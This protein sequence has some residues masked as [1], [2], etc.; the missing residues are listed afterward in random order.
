MIRSFPNEAEFEKL[1]KDTIHGGW[2]GELIN[3]RKDGSEFP[4][5]LSTSPIRDEKGDLIAL[6]GVAADITERKKEH[7][8]LI[9]AKEK[10]EESDRLKSAF[11]ANMSHEI[12][13][14]L[15]AIIGF[16]SLMIDEASDPETISKSRIILTSGM[17]LLGLVEDIL[18][19]SMIETGQVK[20]KYEK[21][22]IN[23]ILNEV[24]DIISGEKL[25]ENK[26]GITVILKTDPQ[27][28]DPHI[29]TDSRKLKQVLIN[30]LKNSLKFTDKGDIEFGFDEINNSSNKFLKFYVK[31]TG[32]GIDQKYHDSIFE[33]FRQIDDSHTRN[34]GGT[35]IGLSIAKKI[36]D[37]FGG[38]I[39]VES[40]PGKGS[41][42]YFIVPAF[43][44]KTD[45]E[46]LHSRKLNTPY[47][48]S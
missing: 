13:T 4:I 32:I 14:P 11:L 3:R 19:I 29:F 6:I 45:V 2:V 38:K 12:R 20:I 35:G 27:L 21:T 22:G 10:A 1:L 25:K 5:E 26:T 37:L 43:S 24:N 8:E 18:D 33:I 41:V 39:W 31:D 16:S 44:K 30:L 17:H 9:F 15:N 23:S 36:I 7:A 47:T 42:F 48:I 46:N 34:F 40:E 28:S